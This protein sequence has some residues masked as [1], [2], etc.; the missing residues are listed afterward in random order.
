[1]SHLLRTKAC[2]WKQVIDP[3]E[4]KY[5]E[6]TKLSWNWQKGFYQ[7]FPELK[8][9]NP[10]KTSLARAMSVS[11]GVVDN[12]FLQVAEARDRFDIGPD[13]LWNVDETGVD[14]IPNIQKVVGKKGVTTKM[15]VCAE[16]GARTSI[17]CVA[18]AAG[19]AFTPM[20]IFK[21]K[22]IMPAWF[23]NAPDGSI[24]RCSINGYINKDLFLEYMDLWVDWLEERGQ[25][26]NKKHLILMDQHSSHT[27]NYPALAALEEVGIHEMH[28][29][30]H[31][32]HY[33]QPL[34]KNP[35]SCF[36]WWWNVHLEEYNRKHCGRA[37]NKEDFFLVFNVAWWKGMKPH[38]IKVAF[39]RTRLEP[40][41]RRKISSTMLKINTAFESEPPL[42]KFVFMFACC[43]YSPV[44]FS[45]VTIF[46]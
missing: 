7:R 30:S 28:I 46:G 11:K 43:C 22:K 35:F 32:S 6:M 29:P 33:L 45:C 17:I 19:E 31:S 25:L 26:N 23:T 39:M 3:H 27:F 4:Y 14:T 20:V 13:Q 1:M 5:E 12:F 44:L 42:P 21:G 36:K 2:S 41:D 37:L 16:K 15:I 8:N 10:Q 24:I 9:K 40:M 18:N 38:N 34:D